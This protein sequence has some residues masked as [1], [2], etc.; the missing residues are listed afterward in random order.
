RPRAR[1]PR[2]CPAPPPSGDAVMSGPE[3]QANAIWTTT[4]GLPLR[5][6]PLWFD[7][8]AIVALALAPAIAGLRARPLAVA[9]VAPLVGV[10]WLVAAQL[11]FGAGWIVAV[12][13]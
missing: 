3:I 1:R 11:A 8:L 13:W 5:T 10:F 4:R 6:V 7:L 12:V 9:L 2:V